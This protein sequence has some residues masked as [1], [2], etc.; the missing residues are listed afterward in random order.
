MQPMH[1]HVLCALPVHTHTPLVRKTRLVCNNYDDFKDV[2]GFSSL[3]FIT[4]WF[5]ESYLQKLYSLWA[6]TFLLQ[7]LK[8]KA[9]KLG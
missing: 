3:S 9:T 8:V 6:P 5:L 4:P 7:E 1:I 2:I